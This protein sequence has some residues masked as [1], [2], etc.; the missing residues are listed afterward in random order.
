MANRKVAVY[1]Q[2]RVNGV[3]VKCPPFLNT[4]NHKPENDK[5][6][7]SGKLQVH[8][9]GDW[10]IFFYEGT[11]RK[12]QKVGPKYADAK[13]A[14]DLKELALQGRAAGLVVHEKA[15]KVRLQ[16][17]IDLF[18]DDIR[19]SRRPKTHAL[20]KYD[21]QEFCDW[22]KKEF[23]EDITRKDILSFKQHVMSTPEVARSKAPHKIPKLRSE[24]T[25]CN[26]ASEV[27]QFY[28][29]HF[30]VDPGKGLIT[31]KDVKPILKRVE[32]YSEDDWLRFLKACNAKH[33]LMFS[34]FLKAGL[35]K[36]EVQFM[37]WSD[38]DFEHNVLKV[39]EKL[40]T[41]KRAYE[42]RPK[43]HE[44]RDVTVP[45]ELMKRLKEYKKEATCALVFP[46][47]NS[48]PDDKIWDACKSIARRAGLDPEQF[49]V[50]R[51]RATFASTCLQRGMD[52]VTVQEQ[53][54]H[55]DIEST[56][57]YLAGMKGK[58]KM[59]K[60][61]SVWVD[62]PVMV[63]WKTEWPEAAP[64]VEDKEAPNGFDLSEN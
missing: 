35:R 1:K 22:V 5:V 64:P 14:A 32:I 47:R 50:H 29:A 54:G 42:F 7:V 16:A 62:R 60:V 12:W 45:V 13:R 39:T 44:E 20:L 28:R 56:M 3:W 2:V 11:K 38:V 51:F 23:V 27:N 33:N 55:K 49:Y 48:R 36:Q 8:P 63:P 53:L 37:E 25:A 19:T 17:A 43:T 46:T 52:L 59:T 30:K 61:E 40:I 58:E 26:K 24:R 18:V 21:L 34:V 10:G 9:E 15:G 57:R 6:L 4:K 41:A 31:G